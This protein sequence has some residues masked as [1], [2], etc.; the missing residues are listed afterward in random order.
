M[1]RKTLNFIYHQIVSMLS[2][3]KFVIKTLCF[4]HAM[5]LIVMILEL[6]VWLRFG[7]SQRTTLYPE[8]WAVSS[9]IGY[10]VEYNGRLNE[11]QIKNPGLYARKIHKVYRFLEFMSSN[12]FHNI[13]GDIYIRIDF[14]FNPYPY[15]HVLSE[16]VRL[17]IRS[18]LF[19]L[20]LLYGWW[21][22]E[23]AQDIK[24]LDIYFT[25]ENF[26]DYTVLNF[27]LVVM[28][29]VIFFITITP[30]RLCKK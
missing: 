10:A 19:L 3:I 6:L 9:I 25:P 18:Y 5:I 26:S 1:F 15:L 28:K 21:D 4:F 12:D 7:P 16:C 30:T 29:Y 2:I 22:E 20:N 23:L 8:D 24:E 17:T 13:Y 11:L 14:K 27:I